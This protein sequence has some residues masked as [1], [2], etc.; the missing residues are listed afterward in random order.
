VIRPQATHFS[1]GWITAGE[2]VSLRRCHDL[3]EGK[4]L[5]EAVQKR[6][7]HEIKPWNLDLL[8][9]PLRG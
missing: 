7:R 9:K 5:K 2:L 3:R 8:E 6:L 1:H 4:A